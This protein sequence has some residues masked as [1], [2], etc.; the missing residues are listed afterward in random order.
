MTARDRGV[1]SR[2]LMRCPGV[3]FTLLTASAISGFAEN[4]DAFF[5]SK[6]RPLLKEHCGE[7]HG[8]KKMKG[9]LRLDHRAGW[10][11]GGDSGPA[12]LPGKAGDS[13]LIK[14]V[15]YRDED[16][17]MPPDRKLSDSQIAVLEE[18]VRMG[19]PDPRTAASLETP[20]KQTAMTVEDGRKFWAWK[21]VR[22]PAVPDVRDTAWPRGD[23]DRFVL[24]EMESHGLK[25]GPDAA[26]QA[27]ARRLHFA[28]TGLPPSPEDIAAFP[29]GQIINYKSQILNLATRLLV[30]PQ[31]GERLA[32][33][34]LDVA[35]FAESSGGGR[36]LLFKDAWRYRD[37]VITA[38]NENRSFDKMLREQIAGDLLPH[39]NQAQRERQLVATAFLALGPAN[40]EEQDKQQLRFDVIDEQIDTIGKA[41]MGQTIGCARCHDHKFDP[42]LQRDYYALAGIF[43]STRTLFNYTD[44]VARWIDTALPVPAAQEAV[45]AA[46]REEELA[47][48]KE[49]SAAQKRAA[50][51][52]PAAAGAIVVDPVTLPGIVVDDEDARAVGDWRHSVHTKGYVA[53][54]YRHD[55]NAGKGTAT[56]SYVPKIPQAGRYEVRLSYVP[57]DGRAK[58]VPVNILHAT[59][60]E[61]VTVDQTKP[62]PIEGRWISLGTW[63]FEKDGA[64]YVMVSNEGTTGHVIADAMQFLPAGE[65]AAPAASTPPGGESRVK[66]LEKRLKELRTAG[67]HRPVTMS[68]LDDDKPSGTEIRVRGLV[69]QKGP[70]VPR[71]VLTVAG[72]GITIPDNQSGRRELADWLTSPAHPLTARVFVNRVWC[73][74]HGEGIVRSVDNFGVTGDRPSHPALLDWLAARFV[75]E[76]WSVKWLVRE[77]VTSRTWALAAAAPGTTDPDNRRL[78]HAPR[79]RLDAGQLRDAILFAAGTLDLS[80]G[81][82]NIQGAGEIDANDTS[83]QNV[84]YAYDFQDT[85]R[86]IYTPA[87]RNKRH[88]LFETFDFADINATAGRRNVSTVAPQALFMMNHPFVHEQARKAAVRLLSEVKDDAVRLDRAFLLTLGRA[89]REAELTAMNQA[90]TAGSDR[91]ATWTQLMLALYGSLDFRYLE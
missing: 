56:L 82:P 32:G 30:T 29:S 81:G 74:F 70:S 75:E 72:G 41:I 10:A 2:P 71:G 14:A 8:E 23:I 19:A 46:H 50:G 61:T 69:H 36:T 7:C 31:F 80:V 53:R 22:K 47:L 78:T 79:R 45:P 12:I 26:P 37:Y 16:L 76:G 49:L 43:A 27:L 40:Y 18:W 54:G 17:A 84:E 44:N 48:L 15:R 38:F 90:L 21:P 77:I 64:G 89:P 13:L 35:R 62:P 59:G 4:G 87:F 33:H 28:L 9:G 34:W 83:A 55:Q 1:W 5:E 85:R 57:G 39:Q 6:V 67:P 91:A 24:A 42:I 52:A 51:S 66:A 25:P 3:F 58:N 20:G 73:W 63:R 11:D 65:P 86:S 88:E 68:V 60:E